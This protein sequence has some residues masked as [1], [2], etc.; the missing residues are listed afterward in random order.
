MVQTT[1]LNLCKVTLTYILHE[2][3]RNVMIDVIES[4]GQAIGECNLDRDTS[5]FSE[6]NPNTYSY[7]FKLRLRLIELILEIILLQC[8]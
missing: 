3:A 2:S 5:I 1:L 7:I 6:R 8:I 4:S